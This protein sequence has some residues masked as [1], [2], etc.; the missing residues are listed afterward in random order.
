VQAQITAAD[1]AN[2]GFGWVTVGNLGV[3]EVQSN[4]VYFP[5]RTSTKGFADGGAVRHGHGGRALADWH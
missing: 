5:I 2:P 4:L 1:I 3:G